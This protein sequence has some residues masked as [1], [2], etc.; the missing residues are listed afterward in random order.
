MQPKQS[1]NLVD[2]ILFSQ[3][4]MRAWKSNTNKFNFEHSI[5]G[6]AVIELHTIL[7]A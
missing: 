2:V 1:I 7:L 6:G 4:F 3:E 5:L